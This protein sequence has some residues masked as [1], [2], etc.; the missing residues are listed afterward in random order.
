MRPRWPWLLVFSTLA[1]LVGATWW[2]WRR[3]GDASVT[4]AATVA[5]VLV[6]VATHALTWASR[7]RKSKDR[8]QAVR[9]RIN[10]R[11]QFSRASS[12][13]ALSPASEWDTTQYVE[14]ETEAE[15]QQRMLYR[16]ARGQLLS[17][18]PR[19]EPS[20]T[21][22]LLRSTEHLIVL[23]GE[24]GAG[25]SMAL[26]Y[27]TQRLA[28]RAQRRFRLDTLVALYIDLRNFRPQ[29]HSVDCAA[30]RR[31]IV[32][33]LKLSNDPALTEELE[34]GLREGTLLLLFDGFDEIPDVL[35]A[36]E[37]DGTVLEYANAIITFVR[38]HRCRAVIAS[39][40]F[41]GPSFRLP[42]FRIAPM[43]ERRQRNLIR[44]SGLSSHLQ[45]IVLEGM[46]GA[47]R[48]L[49]LLAQNPLSLRLVCEYIK[50]NGEFP[51]HLHAVFA[52]YVAARF[53]ADA[54]RVEGQRKLSSTTVRAYAEEICFCMAA[55]DGL[56]L[57]PSRRRLQ[58]AMTEQGRLTPS[59]LDAVLNALIDMRLGRWEPNP[60]DSADPTFTFNHR[61]IQEYFA[62]CVLLRVPDR[63]APTTL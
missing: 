62:A 6:A 12:V 49:R 1:V 3:Y 4:V 45:G 14:L 42:R 13:R 38:G 34:R 23:E 9:R 19:R 17:R 39:R 36:T 37:S 47:D 61:R 22:A 26:R 20:L 28:R 27:L 25:K 7:S 35:R 5:A 51:Q 48:H 46:A 31:Y 63:V 11:Q 52:S 40:E 53:A 2:Y 55:V 57:S 16:L 41:R 21:R 44:S 10:A 54:P 8:N 24:P 43:N 29:P 15:G 59:R 18:G 33:T 58:A 56:G 32:E 60:N 30:V 50:D